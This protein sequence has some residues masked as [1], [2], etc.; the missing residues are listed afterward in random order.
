MRHEDSEA[1]QG[2]KETQCAGKERT[3]IHYVK[4]I[5]SRNTVHTTE[6][7]KC[8]GCRLHVCKTCHAAEM[9]ITDEQKM[10]GP[11]SARKA[12]RKPPCSVCG[13]NSKPDVKA[14]KSIDGPGE[15]AKVNQR[16][17]QATKE[18]KVKENDTEDEPHSDETKDT[19][20]ALAT[21]EDKARND[22]LRW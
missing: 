14:R 21:T 7:A 13:L 19:S 16:K 4:H 3:M 12:K 18:S 20:T 6:T 22:A 11:T 1:K 17:R 2:N 10:H 8:P 15:N 9:E 5:L